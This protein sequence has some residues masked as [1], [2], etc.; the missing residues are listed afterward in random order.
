MP[1][2]G[3]AVAIQGVAEASDQTTVHP[4]PTYPP[5]TIP[6]STFKF[7]LFCFVLYGLQARLDSAVVSREETTAKI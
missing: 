4:T 2:S 1:L 6:A 3:H 7:S 5:A